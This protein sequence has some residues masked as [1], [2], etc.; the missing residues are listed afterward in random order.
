MISDIGK[1]KVTKICNFH[2]YD[3]APSNCPEVYPGRRPNFSYVLHDECVYSLT[4]ADGDCKIDQTLD[5]MLVK[6]NAAK[7]NERIK[8]LGYGSNVNPS[9]CFKKF[10][11]NNNNDSP[12]IVL[13]GWL[14]NYDVV[15]AS[16]ISR[17][18]A[19]P[20]AL[21]SSTRTTVSVGINLLDSEQCKIM[22]KTEGGYELTNLQTQVELQV[23]QEQ[24]DV[25]YYKYN[26]IPPDKNNCPI[27]L[28]DVFACNRV[29]S[30][31]TEH[32]VLDYVANKFD[33]EDGKKMAYTV[34]SESNNELYDK[35]NKLLSTNRFVQM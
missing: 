20:A 32:E 30:E 12:L 35:I 4:K 26:N 21:D 8:V 29:N 17:Y 11:E 9:Q 19:I 23:L 34:K 28:K 24:I 1:L 15:Y 6:L 16:K 22:T 18:G 7:I 2:E 27:S 10:K 3:P 5:Q 31:M 13:L 25:M 14:K 33:F